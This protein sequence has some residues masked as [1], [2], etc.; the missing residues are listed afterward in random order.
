MEKKIY[1][2]KLSESSDDDNENNKLKNE[3]S[4]AKKEIK[5][6]N[7][8]IQELQN[9]LN[10]YD[11]TIAKLKNDIKNYK[12]IISKKEIEL[13]NNINDNQ[14]NINFNDTICVNFISTDQT[15]HFVVPCQKKD[16][17]AEIEEKLYKQYPEYREKN[18]TFIS[19]GTL[20]LRFKTIDENQIG[21]E[22]P[23]I[24]ISPS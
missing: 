2:Q 13:N 14:N 9:K 17:F 19:N 4:K 21:D 23:V 8:I 15:V 10:N 16:I 18:N 22:S 20:V 5:N 3:L 11:S 6:L 12:K 1:N 24:L 7:K